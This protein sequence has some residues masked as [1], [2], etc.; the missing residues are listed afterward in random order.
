M[1]VYGS[2]RHINSQFRRI[3]ISFVP[4]PT[5]VKERISWILYRNACVPTQLKHQPKFTFGT[6]T[7]EH[8]NNSA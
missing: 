6:I 1:L 5:A 2:W 4:E 3:Q 7:T 8:Q